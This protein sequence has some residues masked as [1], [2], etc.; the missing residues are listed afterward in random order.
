VLAVRYPLWA[1]VTA[2]RQ[3]RVAHD[4]FGEPTQEDVFVSGYTAHRTFAAALAPVFQ[5]VFIVELISVAVAQGSRG[6]V[7]S[8]EVLTQVV[9]HLRA[10]WANAL[11]VILVSLF[12]YLLLLSTEARFARRID[13]YSRL[14]SHPRWESSWPFFLIL[15]LLVSVAATSLLDW[16]V[17]NGRFDPMGFFV[18]R[19]LQEPLAPFEIV[20]TLVFQG[21]FLL[22]LV[23]GLL[24]LS[25][26]FAEVLASFRM[27]YQ[28]AD[29]ASVVTREQYFLRSM[30]VFRIVRANWLYGGAL[31]A[32]LTAISI[33]SEARHQ[34]LAEQ[35]LYILGP[36]LIGFAGYW[37][38]RRYV[39][40]YL[41]HTPAVANMLEKQTVQDRLDQARSNRGMLTAAPLRKRLLQLTVPIAC[42]I[43]YLLW[44]GS[45][46][47][48]LAVRQLVLPV[49]TKG[50]LL[51][52]PYAL[53]LPMLLVR[54]PIHLWW[55]KR[56]ET[57]ESSA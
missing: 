27:P 4:R 53:L 50:W 32:S 3:G 30:A 19:I 31:I 37:V 47:H 22:G 10:G 23:A 13:R 8:G 40:S 2:F 41:R 44:T 38:T 18:Q 34:P 24:L 49:T 9:S 36:S 51:I 26:P 21:T 20:K 35:V 48:E 54:D 5:L 42:V 56:L 14:V 55:L 43:A 45:G 52:L 57:S 15:V 12:A 16:V 29:Q 39:M 33:L 25:F 7:G 6:S 11:I 28:P 17:A 1:A 46:V